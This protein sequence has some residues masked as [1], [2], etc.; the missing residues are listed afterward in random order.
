MEELTQFSRRD[1][2]CAYE[3]VAQNDDANETL[4]REGC[5]IEQSRLILCSVKWCC[6]AAGSTRVVGPD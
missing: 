3:P 4:A 5:Q 6:E 2:T 1:T